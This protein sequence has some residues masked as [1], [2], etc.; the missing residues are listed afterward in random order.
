MKIKHIFLT[1][2]LVLSIK[3]SFAQD[4]GLM[5]FIGLSRTSAEV[6]L[7]GEQETVTGY[8]V[9]AEYQWIEADEIKSA[10]RIGLKN[11]N[12]DTGNFLASY[13]V[14]MNILTIGQS[15]SYDFDVAGSVLRPFAAVDVGGGLAKANLDVLGE[16]AESED[17]FMPYASAQIGARYLV[18]RFVPFIVGGYQ[19]A[20]VDDVS[21]GGLG[22]ENA[23]TVDFSG[24][25]FTVGLG[26]IF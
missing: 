15:V 16:H 8:E 5:P 7:L 17:K 23:G 10:S 3:T 19:Y 22:S 20:K 2:F 11:I 13:E 1:F 21:F 4:L 18:N 14:E 12:A 26:M 9:G 6:D 24:A 25:Y